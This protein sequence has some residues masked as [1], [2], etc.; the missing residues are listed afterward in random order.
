MVQV[1]EKGLRLL[2]GAK[3]TQ[4]LSIVGAKLEGNVVQADNLQ[5]VGGF[6]RRSICGTPNDRWHCAACYW[7]Y[8]P[9]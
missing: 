5:V 3:M 2:D 7:R 8:Y 4:D 1:Y 9:L 6:Y